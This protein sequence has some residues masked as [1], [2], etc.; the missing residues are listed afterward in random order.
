MLFAY[1][2]NCF[3]SAIFICPFTYVQ[4]GQ[5]ALYIASKNGNSEG[6]QLLLTSGANSDIADWVSCEYYFI[7]YS[8]NKFNITYAMS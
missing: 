6:V 2:F 3:I 7:V 4:D 8:P 1:T 5:T